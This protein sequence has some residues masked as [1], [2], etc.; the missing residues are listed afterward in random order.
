MDE[1]YSR[2][3]KVVAEGLGFFLNAA[4]E[5]RCIYLTDLNI[6]DKADLC[7]IQLGSIAAGLTGVPF[8]LHLPII[9]YYKFKKK[10]KGRMRFNWTAD[11]RK[12]SCGE[13]IEEI[14]KRLGNKETTKTFETIYD[15]YYNLDKN[16]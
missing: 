5:N 6:R 2:L 7:I 3:D 8:A 11:G 10:M 1:Y 4:S 14:K 16:D 15:E 9:D 12:I 13:A